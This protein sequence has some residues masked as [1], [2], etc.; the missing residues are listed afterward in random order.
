[1]LTKLYSLVGKHVLSIERET[2]TD[3]ELQL[4]E[5]LR[6]TDRGGEKD[7][8]KWGGGGGGNARGVLARERRFRPS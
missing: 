8:G 7:G 5:L 1:M 6:P 4:V 3:R 2:V